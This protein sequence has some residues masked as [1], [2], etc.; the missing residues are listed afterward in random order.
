MASIKAIHY[1]QKVLKDGTSPVMLYIYEE[2][3]HRISL[4]YSCHKKDWDK[5]N[6]MFRKGYPN[7]K[8][9]NLNIR[10]Q[11]LLATEISDDFV[12]KGERFDFEKF[13]KLFKGEKVEKKTVFELMETLIEE[14]MKLG[15]AGTMKTYKDAYRT[16][17]NYHPKDITFDEYDYNLLKGLETELFS[18]GCKGGGISVRMRT[19]KAMF[20]EA[21]RRGYAD[22][23]KSPYISQA[24]RDGYS[25]AKLKTESKPK[26]LTKEELELFKSF[27]F[28]KHPDLADAWRY[29]MFSYY[30]F[31]MNFADIGYLEKGD[32]HGDHIM[33]TRQK[34]GKGLSIALTEETKEIIRHFDS[35]SKYL[36]PVYDE[37]FHKTPIQ[38]KDRSLLVQ[39]HIN[40]CLKK[41][42]KIQGIKT[43]ITFY[44]ARH[45]SA[46]ILKRKG[47]STDVIS[48]ALGH[49]NLKVTQTY[50]GKFSSETMDRAIMVL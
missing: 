18:R 20:N 38:Q 19:L 32:I 34:T 14:K 17:R 37:Y 43:H 48:Q 47:V 41:I 2:K 33:Y 46:T 22:P 6:G 36:F 49:A 29:F 28:Y 23:S 7:A 31:G 12:R 45:T 44:T 40:K 16:L 9:K 1:T 10:K 24:N 8:T 27:N 3:P 4:G 25:L 21:V 13:K 30:T 42:A 15:K 35:P 26:A 5:K 50:L 39:R 11:L